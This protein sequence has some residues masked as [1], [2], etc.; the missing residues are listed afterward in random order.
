MTGNP[1][2]HR[3][4]A[5]GYS[6]GGFVDKGVPNYVLYRDEGHKFTRVH[7]FDSIED[8]NRVIKLLLDEE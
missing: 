3:L 2:Y 7:E 5:K 1:T 8:L 4:R 6:I